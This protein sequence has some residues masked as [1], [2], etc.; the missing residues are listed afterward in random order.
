ML[1]FVKI[2]ISLS[3][4]KIYRQKLKIKKFRKKFLEKRLFFVDNSFDLL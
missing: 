3:K 2:G 1:I 4:V